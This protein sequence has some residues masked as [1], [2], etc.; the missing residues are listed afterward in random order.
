MVSLEQTYMLLAVQ[1]GLGRDTWTLDDTQITVVIIVGWPN[2]WCFIIY[3]ATGFL[4][5]LAL[6]RRG[7]CLCPRNCHYESLNLATLPPDLPGQEIPKKNLLYDGYFETDV[8]SLY[9]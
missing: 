2:S 3:L 8:C 6:L 5:L 9:H 1:L 4:L 7:I